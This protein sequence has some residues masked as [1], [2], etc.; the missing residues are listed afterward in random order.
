MLFACTHLDAVTDNSS[1]LMQI[2][3][4]DSIISLQ[5]CAVVLAGDLNSEPGTDVINQLDQHFRRS[6]MDNCP[7]T[8]PSDNPNKTIDFIAHRKSDPLHFTRHRVLQEP[9]PSDHLP[10]MADLKFSTKKKR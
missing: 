8:F 5:T 10:I 3:T 2:K 9:Y 1:R 6:C 7:H 4:I